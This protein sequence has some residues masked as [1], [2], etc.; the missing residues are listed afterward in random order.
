MLGREDELRC[1]GRIFDTKR[2][3]LVG[4][5]GD[6]GL[7][8]SRLISEFTAIAAH[9]GADIVVACCESHTSLLAFRALSR[10]LRAMFGVEGLSDADAREYTLRP[11]PGSAH[12]T[13]S[14][15]QI[16]FEAIG[17]AGPGADPL[18]VS[19]DGRRRRL[20]EMMAQTVLARPN[21]TVFVLDDAQW[22]DAPSDHVLSEFAATLNVTT[23]ILITAYRSEF[24]GA[25][26]RHSRSDDHAAATVRFDRRAF[27]STNFSE[28][29]FARIPDRSN[30]AG[31]LGNP[32]FAEEIVRDLAGSGVLTGSRGHYR[33]TTD[34]Y[35]HRRPRHRPGGGRGPHRSAA[36]RGQVDPERRRSDRY[37]LRRGHPADPA[38][39]SH[40]L[41][42]GRVGVVR[43]DRSDGIRTATT[44]LLSPPAG[45]HRSLRIAAECRPACRRTAGWPSPSRGAIPAPPM[46]TRS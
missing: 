22:I 28:R 10:L 40:A 37:P 14:D 36:H 8:K 9:Q 25:L 41:S 6:P 31:G 29:P 16:L 39:G 23:S 17:I 35:R 18:Q 30:R 33:L 20:V 44:L 21:R 45:A 5:V 43:I 2:G 46:K 32:F 1:L 7:G 24:H 26:H 11:A 4:I 38:S 13:L 42:D 12:R 27:W 15:A 34:V 3:C 19:I